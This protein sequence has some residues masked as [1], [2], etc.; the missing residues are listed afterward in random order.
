MPATARP[1]SS[2]TS[3]NL[4]RTKMLR[5]RSGQ[6]TV[7][8]YSVRWVER[9]KATTKERT[10]NTYQRAL[11]N[12]ILPSFGRMKVRDVHPGR[13][14][15]MLTQ[16]LNEGYAKAYVRLIHATFEGMLNA[17]VDDG[18]RSEERRV[19]KECRSRWSPYH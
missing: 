11:H 7:E 12:H 6:I 19:G 14:I 4:P 18:I 8:Q 9:V 15:G 1:P 3:R 5:S 17:A 2:N 16:K 13:V 10:A